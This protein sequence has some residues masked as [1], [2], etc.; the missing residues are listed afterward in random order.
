M[1]G[2]TGSLWALFLLERVLFRMHIPDGYLSPATALPALAAMF[3]VW[4]AALSKVNKSLSR[5]RVPL[6]AL[7]AA[8]SFVIMMFNIP[9]VGGSSVHAIGAVFVAILL[10]PWAA[11]ISIS[12]ALLIQAVFFGD[13]GILAFGMNCLNIAVIMPFAGYG[14]YKLIAG[15]SPI[16]SKRRTVG[17]FAASFIGINLAALFAAVE[18]GIQ[19]LLFKAADGTPLYCPYPLSVSIPAM[20]IPHLLLAGPLEGL[21]TAA[22]LKLIE[23]YSPELLADSPALYSEKTPFFRRFKGIIIAIALLIVLTPLGLLSQETAW[24]EWGSDEII[25]RLG[26]IPQGFA[27]FADFWKG[28]LPDYSL[29]GAGNS[30]TG[31]VGGYILSAALGVV[32][33]GVVIAATS[34]LMLHFKKAGKSDSER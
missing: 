29:V 12:A 11:C 30:A 23:K 6:L 24:G 15:N 19:P 10:G 18:F 13:G 28:I 9:A 27:R 3:P 4:G 26:F 17:A 2:L 20:M 1:K 5:R 25:A 34:K 22:A 14:I 32:L 21:I 8:F 7:C 16:G 33:I 31:L